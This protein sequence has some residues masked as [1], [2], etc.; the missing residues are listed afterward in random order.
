MLV[1]RSVIFTR[2]I[3]KPAR[4]VAGHAQSLLKKLILRP[5]LSGLPSESEVIHS[6]GVSNAG[7]LIPAL[8]VAGGQ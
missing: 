4:G 8:S 2:M 1:M 7:K 5:Y 3:P 6:V